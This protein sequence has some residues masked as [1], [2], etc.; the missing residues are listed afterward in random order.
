MRKKEKQYTHLVWVE[1][2]GTQ[3]G[4]EGARQMVRKKTERERLSD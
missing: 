3:I 2:T 4:G 1:L